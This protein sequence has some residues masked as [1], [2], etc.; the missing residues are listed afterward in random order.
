MNK[1][2]NILLQIEK[3]VREFKIPS[4][5]SVFSKK[6]ILALDGVSLKVKYGESFGIVGE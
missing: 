3:I 4:G 1:K 6:T 2:K 5:E